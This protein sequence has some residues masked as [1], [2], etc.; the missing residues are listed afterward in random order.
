MAFPEDFLSLASCIILH[1]VRSPVGISISRGL[2]LL[3]HVR[4]Q[5]LLVVL[6][7]HLKHIS[8]EHLG[9]ISLPQFILRRGI[10]NS[11]IIRLSRS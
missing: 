8:V 10:S 3:R 11:C 5:E 1:L 6:E 9:E 7:H 4:L 2:G